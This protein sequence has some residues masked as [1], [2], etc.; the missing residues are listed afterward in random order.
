MLCDVRDGRA[1]GRLEM[2]S[3][4]SEGVWEAVGAFLV[5][6]DGDALHEVGDRDQVVRYGNVD[7]GGR[8]AVTGDFIE[9]AVFKGVDDDLVVC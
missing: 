9:R 3:D 7:G 4:F 2:A 5:G 6:D 8:G 1:P